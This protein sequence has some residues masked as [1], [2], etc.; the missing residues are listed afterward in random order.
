MIDVFYFYQ[1]ISNSKMLSTHLIV[2]HIGNITH[3]AD[4]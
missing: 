2:K 1:L 3:E 4:Q